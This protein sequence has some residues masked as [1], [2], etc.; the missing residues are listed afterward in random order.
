MRSLQVAVRSERGKRVVFRSGAAELNWFTDSL[1]GPHVIA[2]G[3]CVLAG[4]AH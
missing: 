2:I 4:G 1:N 3:Q